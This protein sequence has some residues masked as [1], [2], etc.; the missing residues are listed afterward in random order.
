MTDRYVE[1]D[2][3]DEGI[4]RYQLFEGDERVRFIIKTPNYSNQPKLWADDLLKFFS[5]L[6]EDMPIHVGGHITAETVGDIVER[7]NEIGRDR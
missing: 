4:S 2:H 3:N 1:Y 7:V 6:P 5:D